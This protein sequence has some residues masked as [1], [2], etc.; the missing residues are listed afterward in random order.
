MEDRGSEERRP[1][2][3]DHVAIG[4]CPSCASTFRELVRFLD[5]EEGFASA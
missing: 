4:A 2:Q 3:H 5:R 1:D